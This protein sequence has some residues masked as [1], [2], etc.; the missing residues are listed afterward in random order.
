MRQYCKMWLRT[1]T[2]DCQERPQGNIAMHTRLQVGSG[3]ISR[4]NG[5][6]VT[7]VMSS[8]GNASGVVSCSVALA[9]I[10]S[11]TIKHFLVQVCSTRTDPVIH[12]TTHVLA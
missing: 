4:I 10:R 8:V 1:S 9:I 5:F 12:Y 11:K 7:P 6:K 3:G 2:D